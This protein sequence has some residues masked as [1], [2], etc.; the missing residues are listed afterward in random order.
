MGP[1]CRVQTFPTMLAD[2]QICT[3]LFIYTSLSTPLKGGTMTGHT[4]INNPTTRVSLPPGLRGQTGGL[5]N[6]QETATRAAQLLPWQQRLGLGGHCSRRLVTRTPRQLHNARTSYVF[7]QCSTAAA[8][9]AA[10]WRRGPLL[11]IHRHAHAPTRTP[12]PDLIHLPAAHSARRCT[13]PPL[14]F[15]DLTETTLDVRLD[16]YTLKLFGC[17][18]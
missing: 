12:R 3:S 6:L 18:K 16:T 11:P 2:K 8:L 1:P 13:G 15:L 7:L 17:C 9:A 14:T 10:H 4:Q 5:V